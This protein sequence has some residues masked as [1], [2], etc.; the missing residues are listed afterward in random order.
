[1]FGQFKKA[2]WDRPIKIFHVRIIV[3]WSN[4]KEKHMC[5]LLIFIEAAE[6][7]AVL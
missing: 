5:L 3:P 6:W 7:N 1:M 2:Y 4:S